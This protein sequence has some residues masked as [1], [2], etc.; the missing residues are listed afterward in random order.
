MAQKKDARPDFPLNKCTIPQQKQCFCHEAEVFGRV[1][2]L[3]LTKV[4]LNRRPAPEL[5]V[6][7]KVYGGRLSIRA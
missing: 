3:D 6:R 7:F 4:R 2:T 5:K 1:R